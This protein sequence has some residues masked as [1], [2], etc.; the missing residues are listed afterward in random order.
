VNRPL[1]ILPIALLAACADAGG[2]DAGVLVRDSAGVVIVESSAPAWDEAD[3]WS[4]APEPTVRIGMVEGPHE[5]QLD[6]VQAAVLLGGGRVALADGGSQEIRIYRPDGE[7]ERALGREGG[8]PGEFRGLHWIAALPGDTLVAYD[9][10]ERRT[11]MFGPSGDLIGTTTLPDDSARGLLPRAAGRLDDGTLV[12][13]HGSMPPMEGMT[14][15]VTRAPSSISAATPD[16]RAST[17]T[18]LLGDERMVRMD[19]ER[20]MISMMVLPIFRASRAGA[21]GSRIYAADTDVYEIS[22]YEPDG[23]LRGIVRRAHEPAPVT[24]AEIDAFTA[25]GVAQ[26]RSAEQRR[27]AAGFAD[28]M[29]FPPTMPAFASL[30][31]DAEGNVWVQEFVWPKGGGSRWSVFNQGGRWL[32]EVEMPEGLH[33]LHISGDAV[34]GVWRDDLEV[35]YVHVHPLM[36]P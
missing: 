8:G 16:G 13:L 25:D 28:G 30:L 33:P 4:I 19:P 14:G 12:T 17:I 24:Q 31:V 2:S 6:G 1:F 34:V 10:R 22:R 35:E 15:G 18:S 36:K 7:F 26:A 23:A 27:I 9:W 21:A 5:Y 20:R 29:E 3:R 11:T 32:G